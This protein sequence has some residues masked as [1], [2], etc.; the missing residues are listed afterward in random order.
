MLRLF[1]RLATYSSS[2]KG[3]KIVLATWIIIV[4]LLSALA[5]SA[6][7]YEGNSKEGSVKGNTPSEMAAQMLKDEFLLMKG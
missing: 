4:V 6:K 3:A 1:Q 7:Q 2:S 5:P